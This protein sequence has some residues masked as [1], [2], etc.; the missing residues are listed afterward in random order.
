MIHSRHRGLGYPPQKKPPIILASQSPRRRQLLAD[1]GYEFVVAPPS[2]SAECDI[3]EIGGPPAGIVTELAR[4]K[5]ADVAMRVESG[6]VLG[7]DT[8]I[9]RHGRVLGKP[10]DADHAG[11]MLRLLRGGRFRVFSG[12]C[13]WRAG[14]S[15]HAAKA[16]VTRL[17]MEPL[18]DRRI[19]DYLASGL[20]EGKAGAFGYQD[21]HDWLRILAG[22]ESNVVGLPLELL[23]RMLRHFIMLR[24]LVPSA[25][26]PVQGP[27]EA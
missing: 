5:A 25:N 16:A 19:E 4:R 3:D 17:A 21:G 24:T 26:G 20:W 9:E 22:S 14:T 2:E 7:C 10:A 1:A 12:L 18:T 8:V 23:E 15:R 6:I 13:L 27:L 11:E